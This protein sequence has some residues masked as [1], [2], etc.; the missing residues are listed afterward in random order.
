MSSVAVVAHRGKSFGGGLRELRAV[1]AR[2]GVT[3]PLW[4]EVPK[5]KRAPK[6]MRRALDAGADLVFVWG[7][8]GM[9]QRCIDALAG[10]SVAIA[11][12]PAGTANLLASNL[13]IPQDLEQAVE[14]GLH[15][16]RR[17][18]DTAL[19]DG[20]RFAVMAG[21]GL[22]ALM[23]RDAGRG[24][25]DRL[26]RVSYVVTGAKNIRLPRFGAR[27]RI[28]GATWFDGKAG[29]VLVG[30]VGKIFGG[31]DV[32]PRAA[33]DDGRLDV[34]VVTAKG[35]TQWLRAL[36]RTA[37][38]KAERSP[39]VEITTARKVRIEL[40]RKMPVE[41]DGGDRP[42]RKRIKVAC[43][44]SGRSRVLPCTRAHREHGCAGPGDLGAR[45]RRRARDTALPRARMR[46][47]RDAFVRLRAADGFSHARSMAFLIALVMVQGVIGLVGLASA[48]GAGAARRC[49][50]PHDRGGRTRPD[51]QDGHR[52][53]RPGTAR[54]GLRGS[55]S[56]SCSGSSARS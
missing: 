13:G 8:D 39:F 49:D 3:D 38:G 28:D 17:T 45:R 21:V 4:F 22:D 48:I 16:E 7:G 31:V 36:A 34:G 51:G 42:P 50:R 32:F 12:L 43:R 24:L 18:L 9:V 6:E 41:L 37:T 1:L 2:H 52:R 23:I 55:G 56:R 20:E 30:N 46:L 25:K 29:C 44:R 27:V 5:S 33:P 10:D 26:G 53:G 19:L 47:V 15:G 11:I 40:D 54:A 14:I 35:L